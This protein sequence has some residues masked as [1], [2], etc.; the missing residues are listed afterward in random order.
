VIAP[1][2][3]PLPTDRRAATRR[4]P[5]VGTICRLTL[6]SGETLIGLVWN[7]S[8]NGLSML[9]HRQ[10]ETGTLLEGVL[11]TGDEESSLMI[12]FRVA[13]VGPLRTGDFIIGGPFVRPLETAELAP[14]VL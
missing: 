13:H 4:Q 5:T 8:T 7:I 14:F 6:H 2:L 1:A 9:V 12:E 10:L 11:L 3:T